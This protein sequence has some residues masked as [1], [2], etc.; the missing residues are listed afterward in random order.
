MITVFKY[1]K[2]CY[3]KEKLLFAYTPDRTRNY[4]LKTAAKYVFS[5]V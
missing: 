1:V 3:K 4:K 5:N 2:D